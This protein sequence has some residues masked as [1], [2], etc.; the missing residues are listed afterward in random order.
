M[1]RILFA[2]KR[3]LSSWSSRRWRRKRKVAGAK[4]SIR[5]SRGGPR[6]RVLEYDD[7][8]DD[9]VLDVS[10][11]H[12]LLGRK[13]SRYPPFHAPIISSR[14]LVTGSETSARHAE[15]RDDFFRAMTGDSSSAR[16]LTITSDPRF[17]H[18]LAI[19]MERYASQWYFSGSTRRRCILRLSAIELAGATVYRRAI[20]MSKEK[21]PRV[22][23]CDNRFISNLREIISMNVV[24]HDA[25]DINKID[26]RMTEDLGI[27]K[28]RMIYYY[29]L[30]NI[31]FFLH[32]A[33]LHVNNLIK[34][35][36]SFHQ[37]III[38]YH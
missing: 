1:R 37:K 24:C 5:R 33:F 10:R 26:W 16:T 2:T 4:Q 36:V 8:E 27:S 17:R 13:G 30:T 22:P 12:G 25:N 3:Q 35:H 7:D 20:K 15:P 32:V 31:I 18:S 29:V 14:M 28:I 19:V 6:L 9:E 38:T 11:W 23:L 21:Y 34:K